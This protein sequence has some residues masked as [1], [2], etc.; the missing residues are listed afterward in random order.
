[1][2][3]PGDFFPHENCLKIIVYALMV[4]FPYRNRINFTVTVLCSAKYLNMHEAA[5]V[6][7]G[8]SLEM[9]FILETPEI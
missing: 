6:C 1:L 4:D 7:M 8:K 3:R 2:A 5:L 9:T